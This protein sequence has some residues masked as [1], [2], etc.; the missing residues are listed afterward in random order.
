MEAPP[1]TSVRLRLVD[2]PL[3]IE[4]R[5]G[6]GMDDTPSTENPLTNLDTAN[7]GRATIQAKADSE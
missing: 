7:E 5:N 6:S 3:T 1:R 2:Y 4:R